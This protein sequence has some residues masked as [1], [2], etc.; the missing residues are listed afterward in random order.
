MQVSIA[1]FAFLTNCLVDGMGEEGEGGEAALRQ[2]L[3]QIFTQSGIFA[4][5]QSFPTIWVFLSP[6][7]VRNKPT[8]YPKFR[9]TMLTAL[10]QILLDCPVNLQLLEDWSGDL[11]PDGIH[12]NIMAGITYVQ[13][14]H[15]QVVQLMQ[16]APPDPKAR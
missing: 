5:C 6:P 1:I 13:D 16:F 7:S 12:Y 8:W 2:I 3:M 14:L 10:Q 11:D 4:F 15:D 9:P